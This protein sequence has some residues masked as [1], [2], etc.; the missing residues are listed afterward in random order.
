MAIPR[1]FISYAWEN[2]SHKNWV[3]Q[4]AVR[5]RKDGVETILDQ[6]ELVP[7]DQLAAFMEKSVRTSDFVLIVCTPTYREKSDNR[8][9]GV[10]YEGDIMTAEVSTGTDRRKFIP[11]LRSESW[12]A[13][14]PSWLKGTYY[15]DL[16]DAPNSDKNYSELLEPISNSPE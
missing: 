10:G 7:G 15:V 9:G 1:V 3:K 5:L 16:R 4:L 8:T 6:W 12:K 11:L 14:A 2:D 13:A